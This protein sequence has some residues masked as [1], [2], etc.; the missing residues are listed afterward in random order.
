MIQPDWWQNA[1]C[2]GIGFALFF[3]P[4]HPETE[5]ASQRSRR[6]REAKAF[7]RDCP[8]R[9]PCLQDALR[10]GDDGVRGGTT[11]P[12]RRRIVAPIPERRYAMADPNW[13]VVVNRPGIA[14]RGNFR[15]EQNINEP[16]LYRVVR[17][18]ET[19]STH[20]TELEAWIALH[21]AT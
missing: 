7:C 20:S 15:L 4:P 13:T 16:T 9:Q 12:E 10:W 3:P 6:E 19:I 11:P 5:T 21:R 17:D 1:K 2:R 18:S 14:S 8:V